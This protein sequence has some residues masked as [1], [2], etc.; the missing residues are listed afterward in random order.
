[1]E[2]KLQALLNAILND[3]VYPVH[4]LFA[5]AQNDLYSKFTNAMSKVY[6]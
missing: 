5:S 3:S 2:G 1:M 4:A 6:G